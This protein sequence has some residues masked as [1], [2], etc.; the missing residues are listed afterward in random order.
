MS[1][2]CQTSGLRGPQLAQSIEPLALDFGPGCD[3]VVHEFESHISLCTDGMEPAW[4][5]LSLFLCALPPPL[6][7]ALSLKINKR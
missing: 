7:L 3:L 4:D 2:G 6:V 1:E 5:A